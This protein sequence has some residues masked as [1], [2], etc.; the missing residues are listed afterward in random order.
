M[1]AFENYHK[2]ITFKGKKWRAKRNG[3]DIT[4]AFVGVIAPMKS[5]AGKD[6]RAISAK[7]ARANKKL[8]RVN[9]GV[10]D[11]NKN[12]LLKQPIMS[13]IHH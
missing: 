1:L 12:K 3:R 9:V 6:T 4:A 2:N 5:S 7:T 8:Q 10:K 11:W 13:M